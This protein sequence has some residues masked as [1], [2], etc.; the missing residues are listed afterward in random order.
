M[1]TSFYPTIDD[2]NVYN[3]RQ[4]IIL[5]KGSKPYLS[6][7]N[8]S[9]RVIT[10]YDTFPYP[11]WYRGIPNSSQAIVA[12]REAGWRPRHDS[13]YKVLIPNDKNSEYPNHCFEGSCSVTYPCYPENI[14]KYAN[15]EEL[16]VILNKTCI[17]QYR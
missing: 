10:D 1:K 6:N 4:Q 15:R 2:S 3:V 17:P 14:S 8:N 7:I 9:T 5:K 16:N 11:R 13:C 12:E